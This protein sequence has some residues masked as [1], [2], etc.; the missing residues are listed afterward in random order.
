MA[1]KGQVALFIIVGILLLIAL[2]F[3]VMR[4]RPLVAPPPLMG[5]AAEVNDFVESC[6]QSTAQEI[7]ALMGLRGGHI[8]LDEKPLEILAPK[9]PIGWTGTAQV[10][11]EV[12]P[13]MYWYV[14]GQ[15]RIPRIKD[16]ENRIGY[17]VDQGIT[18][19][20]NDF[21]A[22][23]ERGWEFKVGKPDAYATVKEREVHVTVTI[24]LT[25]TVAE[26]VTELQDFNAVIPIRLG[27]ILAAGRSIIEGEIENPGRVHFALWQEIEKNSGIRVEKVI[28][29]EHDAYYQLEDPLSKIEDANYHLFFAVRLSSEQRNTPPRFR[30]PA[31]LPPAK[32]GE[33]YGILLAAI[34]LDND[35]LEYLSM[36][37]DVE[38]N[39]F[40]GLLTFTPTVEDTGFI[41]I[42]VMVKDPKGGIDSAFIEI[43][44]KQ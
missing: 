34:D 38:I 20:L 27:A 33:E 31:I 36:D 39:P 19:C 11:G 30:L 35:T 42:P 40:T 14:D 1:R 26:T 43:E 24:P 3:L 6:L 44:V 12:W 5:P 32:V 2:G 15:E 41:T 18:V 22:F 13:V 21:Q 7:L 4:A 28:V 37:P 17:G 10:H 29:D 25:L 23:A 8:V 16:I 9:L